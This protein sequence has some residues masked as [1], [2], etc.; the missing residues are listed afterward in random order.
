MIWAYF[1][2]IC[3][4]AHECRSFSPV[5]FPTKELCEGFAE[6]EKREFPGPIY[7]VNAGCAEV[8]Q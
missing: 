8:L 3:T 1:V 5:D 7:W 2:I 4:Q 6:Q